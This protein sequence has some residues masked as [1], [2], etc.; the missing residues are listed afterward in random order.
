MRRFIIHE[1]IHVIQWRVLGAERFLR[2]CAVGLERFGDRDSP[3]EV[4][5]Y[6]AEAR[7]VASTAGFDAEE[8]VAENLARIA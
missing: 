7:F 3:L 5:A 2:S 6:D 4:M 1:L 8:L